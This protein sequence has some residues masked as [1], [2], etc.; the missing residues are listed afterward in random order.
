MGCAA[1]LPGH[2]PPGPVV[3]QMQP[4]PVRDPSDRDGPPSTIL[5][6]TAPRSATAD[7]ETAPV[8]GFSTTRTHGPEI[9]SLT[10]AAYTIPTDGMESDGT[11]A[12]TATTLVVVRI[13]AGGTSGLGYTY[14]D[15]AAARVAAEL[16]G[17][18]V[19]GADPWDIPT[20]WQQMRVAV[21]N[22]GRAGVAAAAI[23]AIDVALWDLKARLLHLPLI[24]L[25]GAAHDRITPY[26]SGGF[27]SYDDRR[28]A[29]QL[30][31]W[32]DRGFRAV[33]MK[34]GRDPASDPYRVAR[35]RAAVG[36][37]VALFVDGNG[38]LDTRSAV[39]AAAAFADSDVRWYEEPVTS[40]DLA[41][42]RF[43]REHAP[44][45]MAIAAGEYGWGPDELRALLDAGA[46]DV[47]Q[48][49]ATRCLGVT[50]FRLAGA[51]AQ[52]AH[53]PLSSHCAPALHTTLMAAAQPAV[54]L[55]W[56]HDHARLE[57]M[58]FD[59]APQPAGGWI[60][61]D[62]SRPGLG[63]ELRESEAEPFLDWHSR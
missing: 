44:A 25:L 13:H 60:A 38:A 27:T 31:G 3:T 8:H 10:S 12:W 55:E 4:L 52:A 1:R 46:V 14:A 39:A 61:P 36:S 21:R 49:D 15:G 50:G 48:A 37:D 58:L 20:I 2:A 59:G 24:D 40:D 6:M 23:S 28:L 51:L 22:I 53:V 35:A 18:R 54:H 16:L 17:P 30:R 42:L 63:L 19:V 45:G 5:G 34:V 32:A 29:D 9:A 43:V 47:L 56:F 7:H 33:K 41:G 11:L 62:R 26:G 57:S